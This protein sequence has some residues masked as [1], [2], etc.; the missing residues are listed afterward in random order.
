MKVITVADQVFF[1]TIPI[2]AT[3]GKGKEW[4]GRGF[5]YTVYGDAGEVPFLVTNRH[6]L[7]GASK[8]VFKLFPK[9]NDQPVL[10]KSLDVTID[11]LGADYWDA[12]PTSTVDVAVL[13]M[14]E[15]INGLANKG[16]LAFYASFSEDRIPT[17]TEWE[18]IDALARV[19]FVGYPAGIYDLKNLTPVARQGMT[20]TPLTLDYGGMPAF[21]IDASVFPGS[22]G[23]PVFI[24]DR[25]M[26]VGR[27]GA[28]QLGGVRVQLLGV[29]A[30]VHYDEVT[31]KIGTFPRQR[32][33]RFQRVLDLG[34]VFKSQTIEE[35]VNA[36]LKRRGVARKPWPKT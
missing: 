11:P 7:D 12:H 34:I 17:P 18:D 14:G 31:A 20:A 13:P 5:V 29:L 19:V 9:E 26:S 35:C 22:S 21:L 36:A 6:V 27:S 10:G 15:A 2:L 28:T 30:A 23:S 25:G 3:D 32:S 16:Q 1:V 8:V 33:A 24:L 4:S